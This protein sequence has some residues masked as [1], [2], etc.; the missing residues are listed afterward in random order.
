LMNG[1]IYT[2]YTE[3]AG[4]LG[5]YNI[6]S[7]TWSTLYTSVFSGTGNITNDGTRLYLAVGSYLWSV[8]P[9]TDSTTTLPGPPMY[10]SPWGGL[11][12]AEGKLYAHVGNG[13]NGFQMFDLT[14]GAWTALIGI[15]GP[16]VL[17]STWDPVGREYVAYGGYGGNNL[18]RYSATTASW[19]VET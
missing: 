5:V 12:F 11:Q 19:T 7:N 18:Y 6:A 13:S 3:Q 10:M 2:C 17:G 15:P 4:V 9:S 14:A 8:N 16:A 1:K